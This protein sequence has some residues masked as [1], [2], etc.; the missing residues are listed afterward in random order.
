MPVSLHYGPTLD[1]VR[2]RSSQPRIRW[3]HEVPHH[4]AIR[5]TR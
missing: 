1:R 2:R 3:T 5:W 4:V